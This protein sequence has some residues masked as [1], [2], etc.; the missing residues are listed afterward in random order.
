MNC[1]HHLRNPFD[2][3][4]KSISKLLGLRKFNFLDKQQRF[5]IQ[6][7][8]LT[9]GLLITQNIWSD[10]RFFMVFILS[11][12]SFMLTAWSL[13]EDIT[14]IE[15]ILLFILPVLF[16][17]S[18]SLF[19]FLLPGRWITRLI[20]SAIFAL[21]T[22]AIVRTENIYNV[23]GERSIGLLRVAQ[24]VGLL[25]SLVVVFF[26]TIV[27]YSL[28]APFWI[29]ML[30]IIPLAFILILQSLWS[31]KLETKFSRHVLLYSGVISVAIG[32]VVVV[33]SF[34]PVFKSSGLSITAL[35]I[36]SIYYC[37][38]GITQQY[39]SGR[40]FSNTTREYIIA[41]L[42]MLVLL[43]LTTRWG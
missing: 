5:I 4:M 41:F 20:T 42:F 39:L 14:G 6:T 31:V 11:L 12:I 9:A 1:W 19:Y 10:Y 25:I 16:T 2:K 22:Y 34:W 36:S 13:K 35:F 30:I 8:V 21:G 37:L 43:I 38:V 27:I 18:I 23:A 28:R 15:W 17:A 40:M 32:E 24:T 33:L 26:S 7:V 3:L 29:N